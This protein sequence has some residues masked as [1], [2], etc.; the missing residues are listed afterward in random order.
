MSSGV[1]NQSWVI[2]RL[3]LQVG[4]LVETRQLIAH[5]SGLMG[6]VNQEP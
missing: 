1:K 4:E 5:T 2:L 6:A 3:I